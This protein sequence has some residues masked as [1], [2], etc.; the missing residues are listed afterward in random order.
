MR[1]KKQLAVQAA[2]SAPIGVDP[3]DEFIKMLPRTAEIL[4]A[5][6]TRSAEKSVV[7]LAYRYEGRVCHAMYSSV[8]NNFASADMETMSHNWKGGVA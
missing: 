8:L 5:K 4:G 2:A 3:I 6:E 7:Y 1:K